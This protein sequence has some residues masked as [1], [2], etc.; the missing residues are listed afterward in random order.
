MLGRDYNTPFVGLFMMPE[1]FTELVTNFEEYMEQEIRFVNESKY[2]IH[3]QQRKANKL[4]PI[5]MLGNCEIH[6][7]HYENEQDALEK[8]N[9]RKQRIDTKHLY[10]VMVANGAYDEAM[11]TQF[12]GTNA[13][14]K[15]CFHREQGAKLPTG[16]YIPSEDP[17]MGNLYS[18]YQRFV[19][20]FDFSDWI[21]NRK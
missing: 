13:S 10:Y 1:C 7:L 16:V 2:P 14:N 12:A 3:D 11:L 5:G 4:Y 20:W 8:W 9:R 21:L 6:F 17:E 18:Q 15:V 19:G